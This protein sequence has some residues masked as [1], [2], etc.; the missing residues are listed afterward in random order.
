MRGVFGRILG[1]NLAPTGFGVGKNKCGDDG[2]ISLVVV[3]W[4]AHYI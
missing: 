4:P 3:A 1:D 2:P